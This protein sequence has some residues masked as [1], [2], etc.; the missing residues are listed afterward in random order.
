MGHFPAWLRRGDDRGRT[1]GNADDVPGRQPGPQVGLADISGTFLAAIVLAAVPNLAASA[2]IPIAVGPAVVGGLF[3]YLPG[4]ILVS[5]VLDGLHNAPLSSLA[6]GL[7]ALVTGGAPWL[8]ACWPEALSAPAWAWAWPTFRTRRLC[9]WGFSVLGVALGILGLSIAW[10]MPVA[11]L[12]PAVLIGAGGWV[13]T[14]VVSQLG[15]GTNWL[16]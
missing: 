2:G 7:R 1:D 14:V 12:G 16:A 6:R 10:E 15:V 5:S 13:V 9:R 3:I 8:S 4:R 11:Q